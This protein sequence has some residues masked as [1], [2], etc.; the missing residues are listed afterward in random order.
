MNYLL[1]I[2][3]YPL[4]VPVFNNSTD[5]YVSFLHMGFLGT[6]EIQTL[7][8]LTVKIEFFPKSR[9]KKKKKKKK[10]KEVRSAEVCKLGETQ[11]VGHKTLVLLHK[12][13]LSCYANGIDLIVFPHHNLTLRNVDRLQWKHILHNT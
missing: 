2:V 11:A 5:W 3:S 8:E 12:S 4:K 9:G 7:Q 10:S 1:P 13:W 6:F